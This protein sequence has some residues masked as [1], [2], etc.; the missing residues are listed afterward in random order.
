MTKEL[1]PP[2][3]GS[4]A[5]RSITGFRYECDLELTR[6]RDGLV[7]HERE[8]QYIVARDYTVS[9]DLD[10]KR[11]SITV[12]RGTLTDLASVPRL[13]RGLVGRVGPHLEA[14]IIHDYQY[15][16]WQL[17]DLAPNEQMRCFADQLMLVAMNAA[18]MR[19]RARLIHRTVRLFGRGAFFGRDPEPLVLS[20]DQLT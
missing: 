19:R 15:V 14:S 9:F 16:A 5:W 3:P 2:Y 11:R 13:F 18:G 4:L 8:A 1:D 17:R 20:E 6:L 12:P 7:N 10:G